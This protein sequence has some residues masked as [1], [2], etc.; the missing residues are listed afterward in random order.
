[1]PWTSEGAATTWDSELTL[2]DAV[3]DVIPLTT[4]WTL[5]DGLSD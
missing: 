2:W 3:W 5:E 1:M 4:T